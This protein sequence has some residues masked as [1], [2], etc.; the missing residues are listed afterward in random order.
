MARFELAGEV[1]AIVRI[2]NRLEITSEGRTV[3]RTFKTAEH[4]EAQEARL[5]A[6]KLAAGYHPALRDP[7]HPGL[8][9]A[10]VADPDAPGPYA[11]LGDWLQ[12][13]GDPRGQLI[14][15]VLGESSRKVTAE[16]AKLLREHRDYLLGPLAQIPDAGDEPVFEWR[17]GFIH[18]AQLDRDVIG[19]DEPV[20]TLL[21]HPSARFLVELRADGLGQPAI[22]TLAATAPATLRALH[23]GAT[24][25]DLTRLW[26]AVPEL[27][28]LTIAG[29][30]LELG[31]L[32]LPQLAQ[33]RLRDQTLRASTARRLAR[34]PWPHVQLLEVDFGES[35]RGDASIDELQAWLARPDLPALTHLALHHVRSLDELVRDLAF[36]PVAAQLETLELVAGNLTDAAAHELASKRASFPRLARL[37]VAKNRITDAGLAALRAAFP[38]VR[39]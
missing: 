31:T 20:R 13:Q 12:Q 32:A 19:D 10:I 8:E 26:P 29:E 7:R 38:S 28:R 17:W 23:V 15:L 9:A 39:G 36:C 3:T 37:H 14:G 30:R 33:L 25:V 2:D 11:V 6:E 21:L 5:V 18:R 22:D 34:A 24:D 27:R 1:W 16:V 35:F 4:A